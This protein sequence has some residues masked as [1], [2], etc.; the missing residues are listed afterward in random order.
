MAVGFV[1]AIDLF[2]SRCSLGTG[3]DSGSASAGSPVGPEIGWLLGFPK[4][5]GYLGNCRDRLCIRSL[6]RKEGESLLFRASFGRELIW[7]QLVAPL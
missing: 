3:L 1:I 7:A 5:V 4:S 2:S 6:G